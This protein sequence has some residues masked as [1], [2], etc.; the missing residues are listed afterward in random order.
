MPGTTVFSKLTRASLVFAAALV[1]ATLSSGIASAAEF[2]TIAG[3]GVAGTADGPAATASFLMPY[4]IAVGHDGTIFVSDFSAQ[5]IRAIDPHGI[6][7]TVAGGGS[8]IADGLAVAGGYLDGPARSARFNG[9]T[10]IAVDKAG[11]IYV[12]DSANK[13]IRV[14]ENGM[15][16]TFSGSPTTNATDG[17]VDKAGYFEP[18]AIA[19]DD[20]G[21]IWVGDANVGLRKITPAGAVTTIVLPKTPIETPEFF[22]SHILSIAPHG[23]RLMISDGNSLLDYNPATPDDYTYS[24]PDFSISPIPDHAYHGSNRAPAG[25]AFGVTYL[26]KDAFIYTDPVLQAV[27]IRKNALNAPLSARPSEDDDF[28]GAGYRNGPDGAVSS[29]LGVVALGVDRVAFADAGNR[30]I[31]MV[32]KIETRHFADDIADPF[33]NNSDSSKNYRIIIIGNSMLANSIPYSYTAGSHLETLLNAHRME[34]GLTKPARVSL[35][36]LGSVSEIRDYLTEIAASSLADAVIFDFND[37]FVN[38]DIPGADQYASPIGST[39]KWKAEI[40]D[41]VQTIRKTLHDAGIPFY[42]AIQ[43]IPEDFPPIEELA[44]RMTYPLTERDPRLFLGDEQ[45]FGS[46]FT[47]EGKRLIDL[48][49]VFTAEEKVADRHPLFA[50]RDHHLSSWGQSLV[51]ETF[52][53]KLAADKPWLLPPPK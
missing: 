31:R 6:V 33:G 43:P 19:I 20:G 11:R 40:T 7:R 39:D 48:W 14:I 45:L 52:Y 50:S 4:G 36:W 46:L 41:K 1:A 8:P 27:R 53:K 10:G 23:P 28:L 16:R 26:D 32:S 3:S 37:T 18:R 17:P 12:A 35:I 34:I 2:S 49:P 29:P 47:P 42:A 38:R 25:Y 51:G 9:P 21:T 13:C 15:V 30:R 22:S 44:P 5:S 24:V